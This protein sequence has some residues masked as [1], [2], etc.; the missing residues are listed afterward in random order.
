M[1]SDT[2]QEGYEDNIQRFTE[3]A[4]AIQNL[5]LSN[6]SFKGPKYVPQIYRVIA[7]PSNEIH[8]FI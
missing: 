7:K 8:C 6:L 2:I 5:L 1:R 4:H 3:H